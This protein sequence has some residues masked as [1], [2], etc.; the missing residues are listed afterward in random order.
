M[1]KTIG[2]EAGAV[3]N[4]LQYA[5]ACVVHLDFGYV[6]LTFDSFEPRTRAEV[7]DTSHAPKL[8]LVA[9]VGRPRSGGFRSGTADK[10]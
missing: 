8:S 6:P 9:I 7:S 2:I 4:V 10:V 3:P 5:K 1:L